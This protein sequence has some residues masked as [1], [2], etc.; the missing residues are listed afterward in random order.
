MPAD[1]KP[2]K[3]DRPSAEPSGTAP[4]Q[5][6][7][8]RRALDQLKAKGQGQGPGQKGPPGSSGK[9]G[10]R[11]SDGAGSQGGLRGSAPPR[12]TQGKGG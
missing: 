4:T 6:E 5:K 7:L 10:S 8:A 3:T 11:S 2:S 9:G 1:K 12:R